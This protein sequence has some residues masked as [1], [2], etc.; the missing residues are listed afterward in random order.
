MAGAAVRSARNM[1]LGTFVDVVSAAVRSM[2]A[3]TS[4]DGVTQIS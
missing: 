3:A 4:Q 1:V 2:P